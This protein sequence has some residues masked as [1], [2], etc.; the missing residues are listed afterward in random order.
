LIAAGMKPGKE[1]KA[2][3]HEAFEAQLEGQFGD[4]EGAQAWLRSRTSPMGSP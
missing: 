3:L 1:F 4:L 2:I